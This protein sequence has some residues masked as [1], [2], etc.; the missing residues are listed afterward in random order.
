MTVSLPSSASET[1]SASRTSA[2]SET[3]AAPENWTQNH[4]AKCNL[5]R[6]PFGEL[7]RPQRVEVAVVDVE[8]IVDLVSQPRHAV[9]FLGRCGRGKTTRMLKLSSQLRE[10]S[11]TYLPEDQPCPPI[12]MGQPVLIDEAQ[13]LPRRVRH[14]VFASGL[15]LI[16]STHRNLARSL[17]QFGYS[18]HTQ[19][20]GTGNTPELLC[21]VLNR[22]IEA[23]RLTEAPIPIISIDFARHLVRRF[24]TD[25]RGIENHLY[26]LVQTQVMHHGQVRFDD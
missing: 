16:L 20:I 26:E 10:S 21:T 11:Y 15:P 17:R 7:T 22:R 14:T 18:V 3:S 13:R 9:Q 19:R 12:P 23:S 25:I 1:S 5:Y 4:W 2:A 6:N 24:G 8:P